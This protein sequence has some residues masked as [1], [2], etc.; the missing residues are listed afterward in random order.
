MT[1]AI[2]GQIIEGRFVKR[3]NRFIA[4]VEIEGNI[5]ICHVPNTGRMRELLVEGARVVVRR[6]SDESRKTKYDLLMVYYNNV[7][8][9]ID[10]RLPN[11][12]LFEAFRDRQVDCFGDYEDVKK[13]VTFG[14]S[15]FDIGLISKDRNTLIEAKCVTLVDEGVAK[16]PDAPTERGVKHV[17]ELIEAKAVGFNAGVFFIIQRNDAKYFTPHS[18]MDPAFAEAL[19]KAYEKGVIIKALKC[20]VETDKIY[21]MDE[22]EVVF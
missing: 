3:L 21:I 18:D 9:A 8:V 12:I 2:K 20:N 4:Q 17:K 16:F 7:L 14:N 11:H 15:R 10:S 6:V 22:I 13:E 5:E 1:I 19:K